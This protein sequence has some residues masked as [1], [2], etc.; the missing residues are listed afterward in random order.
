[1]AAPHKRAHPIAFLVL[2]L[3]FGASAGFGN[4][5]LAYLLHQHG[6]GVPQVAG[7]I[8]MN[9]LPNTWKV[10]WAPVIDTT[11]S[12]RRWYSIG[13]GVVALAF[14]TM[15]FTPL[16]P[17]SMPFLDG[18]SFVLGV[19]SSVAAM[20]AERFMAYGA[21]ETQK[22]RAGGWSQAG[23]LGGAGLGGGLGLWL[24][25]HT[26]HAPASPWRS[27]RWPASSWRS[28]R[29]IRRGP[30]MGATISPS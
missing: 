22:G 4:V 7:L 14:V 12:A 10:L 26:G 9:L 16:R 18:M 23:N 8:A 3:P 15:A 25:V 13:I 21:S 29:R 30:P 24:A 5:T 1:M 2:Y 20:A 11:L 27:C 6:V 28:A 19:A 17:A